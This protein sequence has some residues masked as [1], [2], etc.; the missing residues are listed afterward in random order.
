MFVCLF[1]CLIVCLFVYIILRAQQAKLHDVGGAE[2]DLPVWSEDLILLLSAWCALQFGGYVCMSVCLFVCL[3]VCLFICLF[4]V[5]PRI[6]LVRTD[7]Y[8]SSGDVIIISQNSSKS[9][10]PEPSS[11]ISAMIPSRSSSE[12]FGSTSASISLN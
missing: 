10:V 3:L 9:M 2:G 12:R 6:N 5:M 8:S 1:V 4:F 11:S 7:Y